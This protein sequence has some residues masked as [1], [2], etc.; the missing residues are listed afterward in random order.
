MT[1]ETHRSGPSAPTLAVEPGCHAPAGDAGTVRVHVRNVAATAQS[2]TVTLL[3]LE[4]SWVPAPAL[5]PDVAPSATVTFEVP[6]SPVAGAR[7]GDY[8]FVVVVEAR[9]AG[10]LG[11]AADADPAK[12]IASASLTVDDRSDVVLTVEPA[13]ARGVFGRAVQ[14]VVANSGHGTAEVN[15][16]TNAERRIG[17]HLD[18]HRLT[19]R[20][21]ETARVKGRV[22]TTRPRLLG[23][24]ERG[25]Y[26]VTATGSLAPQRFQGSFHSRPLLSSGAMQVVALILVAVLWVGGTIAVLPWVSSK[27]KTATLASGGKDVTATATPG[28]DGDTSGDGNGGTGDG[29][30]SPGSGGSGKGGSGKSG[31]KGGKGDKGDKAP[32]A[33]T[34]RVSGAVTGADPSGVDVSISPASVLE[35]DGAAP[36]GTKNGGTA[37]GSTAGSAAS[38]TTAQGDTTSATVSATSFEHV[39]AAPAVRTVATGTA[40]T[41]ATSATP[42]SA[43]PA[44]T[45]SATG[46]G[47]VW[48]TA[49]PRETAGTSTQS[50]S[51]STGQDGTWAVAGLSP[52]GRYLVVLSKPGY[53]TQRFLVTGAT[54][55]A[56]PLE[57]ALV[58]GEGRLS[59]TVRGP[60]GTEGGVNLSI[61]DGTTTVTTRSATSGKVG[62]WSV[63]GL[64]TPS[65]YIV[66][67]WSDTLGAQS[68]LVTLGASGSATVDLTLKRGVATLR[69]KVTGTNRLGTFGG[70]GGLTV[71]ATDGTTI[72]TASTTTA[73][74]TAGSFILPDLPVP[75]TYTVT[76]SGDG[77]LTQVRKVRL[78][79][80]RSGTSIE[81]QTQSDGGTVT[82]TVVDENGTGLGGAGLTLSNEADT[83]K[84]MSSSDGVGSF[85]F[86]GT[87]PGT[88]VLSGQVFGHQTAFAKVEVSYGAT[89][90]TSLTL[91]SIP[92]NGLVATSYITGRATDATTGGVITCPHIRATEECRITATTTATDADG[93]SRTITVKADP[94]QKYLLP[95]S[96]D[97]G[98]LPGRY[99]IRI[100]A[101]GYEPTTVAVD[102]PMAAVVDAATVALQPSPSI[103]GNVQARVGT[104]PT[105]VCV[106]AVAQD[107]TLT[108][109][110]GCQI[111]GNECTITPAVDGAYCAVV[112]TTRMGAYEITRLPSGSYTVWTM[113][114]AGSEY[115]SDAPGQ[116]GG[117]GG[118]TIAL[119]PGDVKRYDPTLDRLGRISLT[120]EASAGNGTRAPAD[121]ALVEGTLQGET[122]PSATGHTDAN[123]LVAFTGLRPGT[124][125]FE[126][127]LGNVSGTLTSLQVGLNQ[128]LNAD[129]VM[130]AG[131]ASFTPTVV[132]QLDAG[133]GTPVEG[134][135]V[136]VTGVTGYRGTSPIRTTAATATTTNAG[137]L[138][139]CTDVVGCQ[140]SSSTTALPLVEDRVDVTIT[141]TG[142]QDYTATDVPTSDLAIIT[143]TPSGVHFDGKITLTG[144]A[145]PTASSTDTLLSQV[146]YTVT[147]A[148]PGAGAVSL[149]TSGSTRPDPNAATTAVVWSDSTQPTDGAG[150]LLRPG[151][152]EVTASLT[153]FDSDT[154]TFTVLAGET[155][156][157]V[158]FELKKFGLL[159]VRAVTAGTTTG[160]TNTIMT[161][162][163]GDGTTRTLT[164][165][166]GNDYVDFGTLATGEY[167]VEI[168]AAGYLTEIHTVSV[169]P[170]QTTQTP[171]NVSVTRLSAVTGTVVS[172]LGTG[173]NQVLPGA[174]VTATLASS[175]TSFT[176][177]SGQDG[178]FRVTGTLE[179][180]DGLID[181]TWVVA[182][183]LA[184]YDTHPSGSARPSS[185]QMPL[186]GTNGTGTANMDFPVTA[187]DNQLTLAPKPGKLNVTVLD[188]DLATVTSGVSATLTYSDGVHDPIN[189][190]PSCSPS[191][192]TDDPCPGFYQFANLKP[193]T[194]TLNLWSNGRAPVSMSVT[195]SADHTTSL[196]VQLTQPA[197]SIQGV[198]TMQSL[199]GST[200]VDD[201]TVELLDSTNQVVATDH[202]ESDGTY[203]LDTVTPGTYT[204]RASKDGQSFTRNVVVAAAQN[205]I[206]D[207][208]ISLQTQAVRVELTSTHGYDLTGALVSLEEDGT[209]PL[210]LSPQPAV[211]DGSTFVVT[212]PQVPAGD[213][214][215]T[216]SGPAGHLGGPTKSFTSSSTAS[217]TVPI[218]VNE[219]QVRLRGTTTVTASTVPATLTA[220]LTQGSTSYDVTVP[221]GGDTV[222]YVPNKAT[223][224]TGTAT[225]GWAVST[226]PTSGV[227]P[228]GAVSA[229]V[230]LSVDQIPTTT[231]ITAPVPTSMSLPSS[232]SSGSIT[233][234]FTLT[235]GTV[236]AGTVSAWYRKGTTGA[237]TDASASA[238][239]DDGQ[240]TLT[241]PGG[242]AVGSYQVQLRYSSGTGGVWADSTSASK[243]FTINQ[244]VDA[245]ITYNA[246]AGNVKASV[247]PTTA[248]GHG[249]LTI[250]VSATGTGGWTTLSGCTPTSTAATLTCSVTQG[251]AAQHVRASWDGDANYEDDTSSPVTVPAAPSGGG[252]GGG[253]GG[254]TP[255]G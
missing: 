142:F 159:R 75:G 69:G 109:A 52:T 45:T 206:V 132:Y 30:G 99:T 124:Y 175:S 197:G 143:L 21:H 116:P 58:P 92:G 244:D 127:S 139:V 163:L 108:A 222:V 199:A 65:T 144:L 137:K 114:P 216:V 188:E 135:Q 9:T 149:T 184:G 50:R 86:D 4:Q 49:L 126:A 153:G 5:L 182:A 228:A 157:P 94:D 147:Q 6:V 255:G 246:G 54:A 59:G 57:T 102:L 64:T 93:T 34:V 233:F 55:A 177:T 38:S 39:A 205:L 84:T 183:A 130:T 13:D 60:G 245:T 243:T 209:N 106:V 107:A 120:V 42:A 97:P 174:T 20:P 235:P 196:S 90:T 240:V 81:I 104:L 68:R 230:T 37:S 117:T 164:A 187:P 67:A 249:S 254:G 220:K 133:G 2:F 122:T 63:T 160:I 231:T 72:R 208:Q 111:A 236:T 191:G 112:D 51:T 138:T 14:V 217:T 207:L 179:D 192:V 219:T 173:W 98:L 103:T 141:A 82:G 152:Y 162:T 180:G 150:R 85:R 56:T 178:G 31:S 3:G 185:V 27:V 80:K 78:T 248:A 128:E 172:E 15:L 234:G 71:T 237:W 87:A 194:Y 73:G 25:S 186:P 213:W 241:F 77:Y 100:T 19:L 148:P 76:A 41:T 48:G 35:S 215:A 113:P 218:T 158:S 168:R 211:R 24:A 29:T 44:T 18:K 115:V 61:S 46:A 134:A 190:T 155:M 40:A 214:T 201:A 91:T 101:P 239:V 125:S 17:V 36:A 169:A 136:T 22:R 28:G 26:V 146:R 110:N 129:L 105:G 10:A 123:G 95:A 226:V 131:V 89:T 79:T 204:I 225:G 171:Q 223:T 74:D 193:L 119:Q 227:V 66:T 1:D 118:V 189:L 32:A 16:A 176:T 195:V 250:Q 212:F 221:V 167:P 70:L 238:D 11:A 210:S 229:Q 47:K 166:A 161:L 232:G 224:V 7:P 200:V 154:K 62:S 12:T 23:H 53:Q 33:Q 83:Y 251:T 140:T 253:G 242:T 145:D 170:G 252:G 202:T 247:A 156:T 181:G 165:A 203:S 8:P 96:N 121:H 88:Y 151:T 198:V 43:T